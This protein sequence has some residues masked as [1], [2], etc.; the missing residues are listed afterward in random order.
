MRVLLVNPCLPYP[1]LPANRRGFAPPLGLAYI[2][3]GLERAGMAV[4]VLDMAVA[5][6][7]PPDVAPWAAAADLVGV[8]A[9]MT[10]TE[11]C[12]V[13]IARCVKQAN[14]RAV[15]ICGGNHATFEYRR[16]LQEPAVDAVCLG[17][18]EATVLDAALRVAGRQPLAGCAGLAVRDGD[19]GGPDAV[20]PPRP[21]ILELDALPP[22]ARHLLPMK[23][24]PFPGSLASSR[25][26]PFGCS[27]CSASAFHGRRVRRHS[28]R[29]V[30]QEI[31]VLVGD[32]GCREVDFCDD[33]FTLSRQR[34]VEFCAL[35]AAG[36]FDARWGCN[37]R[38]DSVDFD[39]LRTM[40]DS[41]CHR[42]LLGA[43]SGDQAVLDGAG[44]RLAVERALAAFGWCRSLGIKA[45]G[46]FIVG[47][48]GETPASSGATADFIRR[49]RPDV[50]AV[51]MLTPFPGTPVRERAGDLGVSVLCNDFSRY[52]Y[53]SP[54][55]VTATMSRDDIRRAYVMLQLAAREARNAA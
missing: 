6:M 7:R 5:G 41:G 17:E 18:G 12:S 1:R 11:G 32:Y 26:C 51:N 22:P 54:T 20:G 14:P 48:P 40:R 38:A 50:I 28:L 55:C 13:D 33:T 49:A 37:I 53:A 31:E 15:V 4:D 21:A 25:G 10:C 2:A 44:K 47:L 30:I 43:E 19:A 16:L 35:F 39:L 42:V 24:Y 27:Y 3:A 23:D 36:G 45:K 29:R 9:N 46:T 34:V 52:D 8:S